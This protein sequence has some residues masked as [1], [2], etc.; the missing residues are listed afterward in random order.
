MSVAWMLSAMQAFN[1]AVKASAAQKAFPDHVFSHDS[2]Q[3][4]SLLP[5]IM[6]SFISFLI[7]CLTTSHED[8]LLGQ[9][10]VPQYS[11]WCCSAVLGNAVQCM[12]L[13][14]ILHALLQSH[15]VLPMPRPEPV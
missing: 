1:D 11:A 2:F 5:F 10:L 12:V 8:T 9:C 7:F 6:P 15:G 4:L 13:T 3:I 14:V